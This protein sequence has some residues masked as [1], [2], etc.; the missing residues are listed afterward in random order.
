MYIPGAG[1]KNPISQA[2]SVIGSAWK[3]PQTAYHGGLAA[4]AAYNVLAGNP[5]YAKLAYHTSRA[6]AAYWGKKQ[7]HEYVARRG[8]RSRR[9]YLPITPS[10]RYWRRTYKRRQYRRY[11]SQRTK[12]RQWPYRY[13][14]RRL[15]YHIWLRSKRKRTYRRGIRGNY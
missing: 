4:V 9:T 13:R 8:R 14:K 2:R 12:Y 5:S 15:P 7:Y 3:Y 11:T 1:Y 10:R 6:A